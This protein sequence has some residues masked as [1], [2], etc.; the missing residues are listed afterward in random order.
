M[1]KE[2]LKD[3]NDLLKKYTI[4]EL[5]AALTEAKNSKPDI[6]PRI[7]EFVKIHNV[8]IK[9]LFFPAHHLYQI[10]E[11]LSVFLDLH[12][13]IAAWNKEPFIQYL[14]TGGMKFFPKGKEMKKV[15]EWLDLES[16]TFWFKDEAEEE[17]IESL[18]PRQKKFDEFSAEI[19][20][21]AAE[22]GL[23]F[24]EA[25]DNILNIYNKKK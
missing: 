25:V 13:E 22:V 18:E 15:M 9:E 5:E 11:N 7:Q 1:T 6:T 23:G 14:I 20:N 3:M 10:S 17:I 2:N 19:R 24:E 16:A 12:W 21:L 8:K 4:E